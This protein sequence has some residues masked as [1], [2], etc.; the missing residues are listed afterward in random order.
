MCP[1]GAKRCLSESGLRAP[2]SVRCCL[3]S[4]VLPA[5]GLRAAALWMVVQLTSKLLLRYVNLSM[6]SDGGRSSLDA[7]CS[8][9]AAVRAVTAADSWVAALSVISSFARRELD[10]GRPYQA[11]LPL[12]HRN[13]RATTNFQSWLTS[14]VQ[15]QLHDLRPVVLYSSPATIGGVQLADTTASHRLTL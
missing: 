2:A 8:I 6:A 9:L 7:G 10:C 5:N 4:Q 1:G 15:C 3:H 12:A 14:A 11:R 13:L